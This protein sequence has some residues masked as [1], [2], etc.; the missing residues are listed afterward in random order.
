MSALGTKTFR[1]LISMMPFLI[2]GPAALS[3][4]GGDAS[5]VDLS[6]MHV[7]F[8]ERFRTLGVSPWGPG[9]EWIAHTPWAGDFGGAIFDNPG[10]HGPF[11]ITAD[12]LTITAQ[13]DSHGKWHSGLLS[14]LQPPKNAQTGFSQKYGYFEICA[15]FPSGSGVWPAFWLVGQKQ[16]GTSGEF[17]V[18]EF[19]GQFPTKFHTTLHVWGTPEKSFGLGHVINVPPGQLSNQFNT[20]GALFTPTVIKTY[21]NRHEVWETPATPEFQQPMFILLDLALGGGWPIDQLH[22]PQVMQVRYIRVYQTN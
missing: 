13:Q 10:P 5:T 1:V 16:N 11:A 15:K 2:L 12:G 18:V 6:N 21:F 9:S 22:G 3:A 14:T 19:Y 20:Y 4:T 17:D 8:N 7:T